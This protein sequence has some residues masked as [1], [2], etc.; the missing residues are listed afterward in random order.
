MSGVALGT[1]EEEESKGKLQAGA[2][3]A[4]SHRLGGTADERNR[5]SGTLHRT[6]VSGNA[7]LQLVICYTGR[8]SKKDNVG[9]YIR[10]RGSTEGP[11]EYHV[12]PAALPRRVSVLVPPSRLL[13]PSQPTG[14]TQRLR[15]HGS[16]RRSSTPGSGADSLREGQR[17]LRHSGESVLPHVTQTCCSAVMRFAC[18]ESVG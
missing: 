4:E 17:T 5:A 9:S 12:R 13:C 18:R 16:L 15:A 11:S 2:G 6:Q 14:V 8:S 3:G 1:V 10:V 7:R